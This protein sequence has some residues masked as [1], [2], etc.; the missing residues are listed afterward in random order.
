MITVSILA[1][2]FLTNDEIDDIIMFACGTVWLSV[3][4]IE[5]HEKHDEVSAS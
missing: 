4:C 3:H 2:R 1:L 5:N